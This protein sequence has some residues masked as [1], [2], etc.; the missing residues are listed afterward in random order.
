MVVQ[1]E[2]HRNLLKLSPKV[3]SRRSA[4]PNPGVITEQNARSAKLKVVV[5]FTADI[6]TTEVNR[7]AHMG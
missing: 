6:C 2:R 3:L 4:Q 5:A 1:H 7:S